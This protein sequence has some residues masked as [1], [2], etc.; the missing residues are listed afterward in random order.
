MG[1]GVTAKIDSQCERGG[2]NVNHLLTG[3]ALHTVL[4]NTVVT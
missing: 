4:V 1:H 3:E 2:S